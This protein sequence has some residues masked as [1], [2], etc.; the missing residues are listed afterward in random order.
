ML[1]RMSRLRV[2]WR[3][4]GQA[5]IKETKNIIKKDRPKYTELAQYTDSEE[6]AKVYRDIAKYLEEKIEN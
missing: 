1:Y 6:N 2:A 3:I 5:M 4:G